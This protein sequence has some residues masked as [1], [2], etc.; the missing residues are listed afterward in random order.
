MDLFQKSKGCQHWDLWKAF[1]NERLREAKLEVISGQFD[2]I[3]SLQIDYSPKSVQNRLTYISRT[4]TTPSGTGMR[5]S[6]SHFVCFYLFRWPRLLVFL[7]KNLRLISSVSIVCIYRFRSVLDPAVGD[8][9]DY[10][11]KKQTK[12]N[13]CFHHALLFSVCRINKTEKVSIESITDVVTFWKF[14][15]EL[16]SDISD[17]LEERFSP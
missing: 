17:N 10:V 9:C 11:T 4:D 15:M 6:N 2:C 3:F 13:T 12:R 8:I 14:W 1:N 5:R 16:F 7:L